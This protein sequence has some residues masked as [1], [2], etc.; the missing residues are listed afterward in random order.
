MASNAPP[1]G[2]RLF[3]SLP[4]S[5][6]STAPF[7]LL[8]FLEI[9]AIESFSSSVKLSQKQRKLRLDASWHGRRIEVV[10]ERARNIQH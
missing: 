6:F 5:R 3:D 1:R 2:T 8:N 7:N 10:S 4:L 9:G